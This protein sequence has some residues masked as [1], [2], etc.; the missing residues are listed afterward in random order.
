MTRQKEYMGQKCRPSFLEAGLQL[1]AVMYCMGSSEDKNRKRGI[2]SSTP[3]CF[4]LVASALTLGPDGMPE[5][6][7][8]LIL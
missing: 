1:R 7:Y 8:P 3:Y 2:D 4:I 6:L 5:V